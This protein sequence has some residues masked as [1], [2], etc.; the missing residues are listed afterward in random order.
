[1]GK[2]YKLYENKLERAWYDSSNIV[3]S[4]CDDI[5][6]ELKVVRITFKDGRTYRYEGVDVNDYLMFRESLSQ[7]KGFNKYL[8]KY[9]GVKI[10]SLDVNVLNETLKMLMEEDE[11]KTF[12]EI[13]D[14]KLNVNINGNVTEILF[15]GNTKEVVMKLFE[16]FNI[17]FKN[18]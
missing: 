9:D 8:K 4:E 11:C 16:L 6:N 15:E 5:E 17:N 13:F 18:V 14:D 10:D 3:Y 2:I 7:G 12:V 1:M